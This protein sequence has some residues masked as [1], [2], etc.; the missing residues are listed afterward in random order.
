MVLTWLVGLILVQAGVSFEDWVV[1]EDGERGDGW[2]IYCEIERIG[3]CS[4]D[5][6]SW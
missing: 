5:W 6:A 3:H 4:G 1:F 2:L